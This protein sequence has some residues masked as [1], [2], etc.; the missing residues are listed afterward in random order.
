M[1]RREVEHELAQVRRRVFAAL[2]RRVSEEGDVPP[3]DLH[4]LKSALS[5]LG[6]VD[7]HR[8]DLQLGAEGAYAL[9]GYGA[10]VIRASAGPE[11]LVVE[12]V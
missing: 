8:A 4:E 10:Q 6:G 5:V 7:L 12:K 1:A 2:A 9:T 3:L 11:G